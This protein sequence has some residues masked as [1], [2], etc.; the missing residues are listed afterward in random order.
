MQYIRVC[1]FRKSGG[2]RLQSTNDTDFAG[3]WLLYGVTWGY[4]IAGMEKAMAHVQNK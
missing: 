4:A 1:A 2:G 3:E